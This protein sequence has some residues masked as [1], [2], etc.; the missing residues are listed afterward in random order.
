MEH[1]EITE[2][3][4]RLG[5]DME[6]LGELYAAFRLDAPL[7]LDKLAKAMADGELVEARKQ[8]HSIKGAAATVGALASRQL[9]ER[10]EKGV[11][12]LSA[13][14]SEAL[15]AELVIELQVAF[16]AMDKAVEAAN[17]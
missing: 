3:L 15:R 11:N 2:T 5:G 1:L 12:N 7:K 4:A 13:Q 6:L 14:E 16:A 9:A 17:K 10:L 8:A